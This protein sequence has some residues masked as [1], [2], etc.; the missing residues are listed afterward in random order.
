MTFT[1]SLDVK[2]WF[3][4]AQNDYVSAV[5]L[6]ERFRPSIEVV[7]YLCQQSAEKILKAYNIATENKLTRIHVLRDLLDKCEHYSHDFNILL[8]SCTKLT[9]YMS[10]ARY[11]SNIDITDY[12]MK[13]A[14]IHALKILDF[15]K[16]KLEELGFVPDVEPAFNGD[17]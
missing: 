1:D 3:R 11:P 10:L 14:L 16:A 12:D 15:T 8:E 9:P 4:F 13:Q 6:S 7:C 5:A 17:R 2:K